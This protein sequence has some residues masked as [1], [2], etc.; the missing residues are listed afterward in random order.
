MTRAGYRSALPS[1]TTF[2]WLGQ[3]L[4]WI[5]VRGLK[6]TG[7]RVFP[8]KFSDHHACWTTVKL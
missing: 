3:R 5:W 6:S 7:S 4:D 8:L 2:D 1:L